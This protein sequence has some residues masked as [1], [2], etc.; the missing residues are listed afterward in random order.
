[1]Q[2]MLIFA[3]I[4]IAVLLI[5]VVEQ[6]SRLNR[7]KRELANMKI[8]ANTQEEV[9]QGMKKSYLE[10][11]DEASTW[12]RRYYNSRRTMSKDIKELEKKVQVLIGE[13]DSKDT[14]TLHLTDEE[15][16]NSEKE[17]K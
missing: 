11:V 17:Q 1:M 13:D 6:L 8:W 14:V 10:K 2:S 15:E 16:N 3:V 7:L 4:V 12:R 9:Y 5:I